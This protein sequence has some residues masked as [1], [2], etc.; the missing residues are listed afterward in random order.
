[1]QKHDGFWQD[2]TLS[3][4]RFAHKAKIERAKLKA[5]TKSIFTGQKKRHVDSKV[6]SCMPRGR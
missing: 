3:V 4:K 5:W 6:K 2:L 1:M